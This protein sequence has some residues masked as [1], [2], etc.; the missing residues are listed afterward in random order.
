MIVSMW[1]DDPQTQIVEARERFPSVVA[2]LP[3]E[4]RETNAPQLPAMVAELE[5]SY[6]AELDYVE[7]V[8]EGQATDPD[9]VSAV[10]RELRK[11]RR[12]QSLSQERTHWGHIDEI[13]DK[14][15]LQYEGMDAEP[16]LRQLAKTLTPLRDADSEILDDIKQI[17]D[18]AIAAGQ[19][20]EGHVKPGQLKEAK[21]RSSGSPT[22]STSTSS[23]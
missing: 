3:R 22:T 18:R 16:Q 10:V 6:H 17:L 1:D 21:D 13:A 12:R 5:K 4:Y 23:A 8:A 2:T 15:R 14:M 19:R 7:K 20:I 11:G 9:V